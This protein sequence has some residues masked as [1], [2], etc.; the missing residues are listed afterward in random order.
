MTTIERFL[1][2]RNKS[3]LVEDDL[4]SSFLYVCIIES[5]NILTYLSDDRNNG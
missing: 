5:I 2:E 1:D 4:T 3:E